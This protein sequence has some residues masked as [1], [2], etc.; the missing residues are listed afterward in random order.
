VCNA[1]FGIAFVLTLGFIGPA[2]GAA[3]AFLIHVVTYVYCIASAAEVPMRAV[4]PLRAY[5]R[6]LAL[7]ALAGGAGL[8]VKWSLSGSPAT[9]LVLVLVVVLGVFALLGS[10]T[11]TIERADWAFARDWVRLRIIK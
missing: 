9:T 1:G 10:V 3:A 11:K 4:F 8:A 7:A 2:V 6:V 5:L